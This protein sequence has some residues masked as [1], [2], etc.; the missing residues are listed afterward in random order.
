MSFE[1]IPKRLTILL[2]QSMVFRLP[3]HLDSFVP[4]PTSQIAHSHHTWRGRLIVSGMRASDK[5]SNQELRVSAVEADGD[6]RIELW[7]PEFFIHLTHDRPILQDFQ[8][9]VQQ[10]SPPLPFST[11]LPDRLRDPNRHNVNQSTFRSLS[12][13][14]LDNRMLGIGFWN[15][16][17]PQAGGVVFMPAENS[18]ALLVGILFINTPIPTS[19]TGPMNSPRG[20]GSSQLGGY[21]PYQARPSS[22]MLAGPSRGSIPTISNTFRATSSSPHTSGQSPTDDDADLATLSPIRFSSQ[23]HHPYR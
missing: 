22:P 13:L 19:V 12:R 11:F 16:D 21:S 20:L 3:S 18:S 4:P 23:P 6:N 2:N 15:P 14:L 8:A 17:D 1:P 10:Q 5:A 7:P 9:W